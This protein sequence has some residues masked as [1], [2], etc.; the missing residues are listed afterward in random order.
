MADLENSSE[1]LRQSLDELRKTGML[2]AAT[3]DKLN[4]A[5]A[6]AANGTAELGDASKDAAANVN[7]FDKQLVRAVK[8]ITDAGNAIRDNREDFRSLNPAIRASGIALGAAGRKIGGAVEGVGEAVSGLSLILGPKG[9]LIGMIGGGLLSGLGKA[10]GASSDAAA[11]LA[12]QFGEF[13]TGELQKVV[14]AYRQVGAVGGIAA[15]GMTEL[16]D[17]AISAGL[18]VGQFAKII[19]NNSEVLAKS[20][21]STAEGAKVLSEIAKVGDAT[22][23]QFYALGMSV[24]Q[25]RDFQAKFLEQNRLTGRIAMG[26][27][28]ALTEA[29]KA[30]IFQLDELAR[31]TGLSREQAAKLLDEQ[32]KN[33][34]FRA[35]VRMAEREYG[36]AAAQAMRDS[37]AV[38]STAN[39]EFGQGFADLMGPGGA[40]TEAAKNLQIATGNAAK[41]IADMVRT[42]QISADQGAAM[43]RQAIRNRMEGLGGDKYLGLVGGVEGPM[44]DLLLGM[45][46]IAQSNN[47]TVVS[48]K[49]AR[50]ESEAARNAQDKNTKEIIDAQMALQKMAVELDKL[51]KEKI[52][53][54]AAVAVKKFTETLLSSVDYINNK[55]G[56]GTSSSSTGAS[57]G[58]SYSGGGAGRGSGQAQAPT[59][60]VGGAGAPSPEAAGTLGAIRNMIGR[61]ESNGGDY[62]IMV[63]GK[64]GNLTNMTLAQILEQQSKM[65]KRNGFE[66]S[67]LGK[68]Q[69]TQGTLRDLINKTG[70]DV[71]TTMFDQATQDKLADELIV[72]RGG[73]N[74]YAAGAI[75]KEKFMRN[76]STIW[77]GLPMD[78]SGRSYYQGV[79]SNKATIGF[80]EAMGSFAYGGISSGPKSGY[81][82]MLHGTEAVIPLPGGRSVPVEMTGMT[83][84]IGEQVGMMSAQLDR[85]DEMV[86]LMRTSNDTNAKILR[87]SQN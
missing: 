68:Y 18:S 85:L 42:G 79:G 12:V 71:N 66:S 27:T 33:I 14:E 64:K 26:D 11:Q 48:M 1:L 29:S 24:E 60:G 81:M 80:D 77:A 46:D 69:I 57:P 86:S 15:G 10:I 23:R 78:A 17:Q 72:S 51:V 6:K 75:S 52:L 62:N 30:Y 3:L 7:T 9:K 54:N 47:M 82:S 4:K 39:K 73:Y 76:L 22:T 55:L 19:A 65:N 38:V 20:T 2:T 35:S 5:S 34:R 37:V 13:A 58:S 56:V 21:G 63:G 70:M 36:P 87:A 61:A 40:S 59:T 32:N 28:R 43:I 84:K 44:K 74:K 49:K 41:G 45:D 25:T 31:I 83:D 67:A 8:N 16:Y 50:A 53:P